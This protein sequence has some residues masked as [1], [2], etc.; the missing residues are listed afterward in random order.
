MSE[1]PIDNIRAPFNYI[2]KLPGK[3]VRTQLITFLN[4]WIG[5]DKY[6]ADIISKTIEMLIML[7]YCKNLFKFDKL[8]VKLEF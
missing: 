4:D 8:I 6:S 7:V 1:F 5:A 3:L 2:S